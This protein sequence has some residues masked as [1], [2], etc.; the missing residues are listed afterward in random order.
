MVPSLHLR[1][2][3]GIMH[4]GRLFT[5]AQHRGKTVMPAFPPAAE[6]HHKTCNSRVN[7]KYAAD[8]DD[9]FESRKD[10]WIA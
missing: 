8:G 7:H 9:Q 3:A 5:K 2:F 4:L 10:H 6:T 1:E